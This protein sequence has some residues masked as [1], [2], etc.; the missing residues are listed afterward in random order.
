MKVEI[1]IFLFLFAL[2]LTFSSHIYGNSPKFNSELIDDKI[3]KSIYYNPNDGHNKTSLEYSEKD[4][5]LDRVYVKSN[6]THLE[7]KLLFDDLLK[8][9][10]NIILNNNN[11]VP[12]TFFINIFI[13]SDDDETTGF[14]GYNYR[15]YLSHNISNSYDDKKLIPTKN[16]SQAYIPNNLKQNEILEGEELKEIIA[17]TLNS[18]DLFGKL[19]WVIKG[20]ELLDYEFQPIFFSSKV[21]EKYISIIPSGLK[22]TLDLGQ[23]N[24]P[25]NYA[26]LIEAGRKSEDY[27]FSN[28]FGKIHIPHPD[29]TVND[30]TI[31]IAKGRN[32]MVLAFNNT[33]L[34]NLNVKAE[35]M[36]KSLSDNPVL[37]KFS[38]G[39]HFN[40]L[41]GKGALPVD[42]IVNTNDIQKNIVIPLNLSYSVIGENDFTK[43]DFNNSLTYEHIYNKIVYLNFKVQ[44]KTPLIN[45]S[46]IPSQYIAVF[47]GAVFSFF[48]PSITRLSKEY[49]QKRHANAFLKD[50]LKEQDSEDPNNSIKNMMRNLRIIKHEFIRGK[51]T[52]D[53]YEIL[54][55]NMTDILKD[56]ITKN[57][58]NKE[59]QRE[60]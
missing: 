47:I 24:Y 16:V 11:T 28:I 40:M 32:S 60:K 33:G 30:K 7:I 15:Y 55:D 12:N 44:G 20:Y 18:K 38:Q 5:N 29:L 21:N 35:M 27:K 13:D 8:K 9:L 31:D 14:L 17:R 36:N 52:K 46:E 1:T 25:L 4:M 59:N 41:D 42:V 6:G 49:I 58:N 19:D 53:Q 57:N 51:I 34:Y 10:K 39:N 2:G 37:I 26:L 3:E 23:I 43:S 50:I 56:L 22:I 48:I 54:K 45:F